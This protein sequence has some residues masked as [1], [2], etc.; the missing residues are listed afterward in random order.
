MT[1]RE[2]RWL[3][4]LRQELNVTRAAQRLYITQPSLSQCLQRAEEELGFP[5]FLRSRRKITETEQGHRYLDM[6]TEILTRYDNCLRDIHAQDT[7]PF[8]HVTIGVTPY[9]NTFLSGALDPLR[10]AY[11]QLDIKI[12]ESNSYDLVDKFQDGSIQVLSTNVPMNDPDNHYTVLGAF[13]LYILLRSG[14]P[15]ANHA[16]DTG[17]EYPELDPRFL[18]KEPMAIS[19]PGSSSRKMALDILNQAGLHP[20]FRQSVNRPITLCT[21]ASQGIASSLYALSR[22][23]M[24]SMPDKH[25]IYTIPERYAC[26]SSRRL[27]VCRRSALARFPAGFYPMLEDIFRDCL[28]RMLPPGDTE[29]IPQSGTAFF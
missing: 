15:A 5:L 23:V 20:E 12:L 3:L 26:A 24:E 21:L 9:V 4:V 11:P 14:S 19:A 25:C 2:M 1:I 6:L 17:G 10:R 16:V 29:K 8:T 27:L 13:R 22:E 28:N 18:E 7:A